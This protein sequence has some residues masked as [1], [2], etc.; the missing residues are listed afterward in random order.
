MEEFWSGCPTTSNRDQNRCSSSRACGARA[1][2]LDDGVQQVQEAE[3]AREKAEERAADAQQDEAEIKSGVHVQA[4]V[5]HG[6]A[7][8]HNERRGH[9]QTGPPRAAQ[10]VQKTRERKIQ[11]TFKL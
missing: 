7:C 9:E 1:D 4:S 11:K 10:C 3:R 6:G 8:S 5:G 2:P